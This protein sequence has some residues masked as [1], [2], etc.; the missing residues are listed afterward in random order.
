MQW[1]GK[2]IYSKRIYIVRVQ[3]NKVY[4]I[5]LM[6]FL[7]TIAWINTW[8]LKICPKII[9]SFAASYFDITESEIVSKKNL[10]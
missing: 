1:S 10:I 2:N 5:D 3:T 6:P 8:R 4:K 9:R 7:Q